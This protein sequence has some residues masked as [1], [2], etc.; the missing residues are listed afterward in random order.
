MG[1]AGIGKTRLASEFVAW[2]RAQG[3]EVLSGHAFELGGRLPYQPLVEALRKRLEEENAPEDLLEDLWLAE[4][5]RL[6]P[7]L[8]VRY[9]DLPVPTEDELTAKVRLFEAVAR[10]LDALAERAPLVLLLDDLQ[11]VDETSL[12]LLRYLARDWIRHDNR[13]LLLGT[14]RCEGLEPKSQLADLGRDLPL[15]Q[16]P[17][18]PLSRA[19]TL[20]LIEALAGQEHNPTC[21]SRAVPAQEP[22]R[23]LVAL[24]GFLFAQTGG[25]PLYLLET[26][27]LLR[28]RE[29]LVPRLGADGVF[30]LEPTV[31]MA[32]AL[33]QEQSRHELLP[34]SVR[35]MLLARLAKL[36]QAARQLVL[37]CAV[38]GTQASAPRLW[39]L[40]ELGR[41]DGLEALEETIT[42]G[43]LREEEAGVDRP[44]RYGFAHDL[45]RE[46]V[47]TEL[48]AA[49]RQVMHQRV[50]A[51][52]ESEGA[53]TVELA[54]HARASGEVAAAYGYS[55]Q[56]GVEAAAVFAVAD[57]IGHY[58]QA[59]ALL[60]EHPR[61]QTA[62]GAAEVERL[63]VHLGQAYTLQQAWEQAEQA[64]EELLS[65]AR[66]QSLPALVS[67]T[68]NRLNRLAILAVQQSYDRPKVRALLEE[69]WRMAQTSHDQRV[70]AET[71]WNLAQILAI[72]W[73]APTSALAQGE[74]ALSLARA[75]HEQELEARSLSS[76]GVIHILRGAFEE[77]MP[78]LEASLG[79]YVALG[80]EP[81]ASPELSL[82]HF[83]LGAPLTQSLT[84][85]ASEAWCWASL[86]FA[87][88]ADSLL[89]LP[90][91]RSEDRR[92]LQVGNVEA[93]IG[94]QAFSQ[95]VDFLA[96]LALISPTQQRLRFI[97][98]E[99]IQPDQDRIIALANGDGLHGIVG[100]SLPLP[101]HR[102]VH[103][104][105]RQGGHARSSQV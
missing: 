2:A 33:A 97:M 72:V 103:A 5:S 87:Q 93:P 12:D 25:H 56:A 42:S 53:P 9:P 54:Y 77:A 39:Q 66:Q 15:S 89:P 47:Y 71:A 6:L 45:M 37:A 91:P 99:E 30:R 4:L 10:L 58:Q 62:L 105:P 90:L 75:S 86:A 48:G 40:A 29:W 64:Y 60:Q 38:L 61:L 36:A 74:Q 73:H 82:P 70:L 88:V 17:L 13:V 16:V 69:A 1:E 27:K 49:R 28:E 3:A 7:E 65:Y 34:S 100:G 18:Q 83:L 95:S 104:Q 43:I 22:E 92:R 51:L 26:L 11:W 50:L 59:R 32:A 55:V 57:A 81:V 67:L 52:L 20:Q 44:G 8:R 41:P 24:G 98:P 21:S 79:L 76:L 94:P 35:A 63:S 101:G 78:C 68:L 85:R 23:P 31:D 96:R 46:V 19:Q 102:T 14:L 84:N 80:S